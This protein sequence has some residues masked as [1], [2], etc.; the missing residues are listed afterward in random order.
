MLFLVEKQCDEDCE[1]LFWCVPVNLDD[2]RFHVSDGD[3]ELNLNNNSCITD[4]YILFLRAI[5]GFVYT[6]N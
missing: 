1:D 4:S 2:F 5:L 6:F 3:V